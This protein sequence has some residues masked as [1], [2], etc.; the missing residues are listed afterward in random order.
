MEKKERFELEYSV[1]TSPSIIYYRINNPSG[2][3]EWF[4]D[5]VN[6]KN[7][8]YKFSWSDSELSAKLIEK[9]TNE[10]VK[11]KWEESEDD[12]FFEIRIVKQELS[13]DVGL[14]ITDFASSDERDEIEDMWEE[15]IQE[16]KRA[17][18]V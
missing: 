7:N 1:N 11:F 18:G 3:E 2:L 12:S 10:Y 8:I 9:K 4:A 15:Q 16:L 5:K 6:V 14:Q 13:G 17:L